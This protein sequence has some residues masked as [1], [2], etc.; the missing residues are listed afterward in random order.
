MQGKLELIWLIFYHSGLPVL[1]FGHYNQHVNSA[2]R[3]LIQEQY[4]FV[5]HEATDAPR[6]FV[7]ETYFL[8]T[9]TGERYFCKIISKPLFIPQVV[10][11]LPVL[12][13]LHR[14]GLHFISYPI[15]T[16]SKQLFVLHDNQL[17]VIFNYINAHQ[18]YTYS[19][20]IL[21]ERIGEVHA[22]TPRIT[23]SIPSEN[24]CF[25]YNDKLLDNLRNNFC[26]SA[27]LLA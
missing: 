11:S 8:E 7:A 10:G 13:E 22:L 2:R 5:I 1:C 9:R 12:E 20:H 6:Q 19:N 4:G 17:L 23:I 14:K 18:G 16:L 21:G 24:F 25:K 27:K 26:Q 3:T 15:E